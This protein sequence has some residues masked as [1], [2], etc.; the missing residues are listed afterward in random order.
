MIRRELFL[1]YN[2]EKKR[3]KSSSDFLD[4]AMDEGKKE[5]GSGSRNPKPCLEAKGY[6]KEQ[7]FYFYISTLRLQQPTVGMVSRGDDGRNKR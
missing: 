3:I 1:K 6:P 5:R 2:Q 4:N 7:E